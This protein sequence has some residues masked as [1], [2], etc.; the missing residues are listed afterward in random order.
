MTFGAVFPR[1]MRPTFGPGLAGAAAAANWWEAGGVT[2]ANCI[3]AYTPKGAASLAA[4]YDNNAAPGNGLAD[5][6]YDAAPGV[7]PTWASGTG[8]TFNGI[9]Q[10]LI[11][12]YGF[13][14]GTSVLV[15]YSGVNTAGNVAI[16]GQDKNRLKPAVGATQEYKYGGTSA[17]A[18]HVAAA[19]GVM[20]MT[21]SAA[22]FD[23][24]SLGTI[25]PGA[26]YDVQPVWIGG[27]QPGSYSAC[28]IEALAIYNT[29][30]SAPQVL[31]VSTA[32]AAL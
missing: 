13:P 12:S 4:S 9:N 17:F 10:Y 19:A 16:F 27:Q 30:L 2:A 24:V 7:A 6:T 25:T 23:G 14:S 15:R 21:P 8:W 28:V 11:C 20:G 18:L 22:Y 1:V 29:T 32:M 31:A 26:L 3:A 5:G